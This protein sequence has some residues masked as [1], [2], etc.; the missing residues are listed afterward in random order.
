M[1]EQEHAPSQCGL[2][3]EMDDIGRENGSSRRHGELLVPGSL[4]S[5]RG[6]VTR[7]STVLKEGGIGLAL[8]LAE[9]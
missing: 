1:G 7:N 9:V 2:S 5:W 4:Q 8:H 6:H 3:K